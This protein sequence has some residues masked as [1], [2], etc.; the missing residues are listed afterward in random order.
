[1]GTRTTRITL[2]LAALVGAVPLAVASAAGPTGIGRM[3]VTPTTLT[4][5]S[6][7]NELTF[8]FTANRSLTGQTI[9]D[10]PRG[11][12]APQ[13][14]SASSP[15]Y[16]ELK[17]GTCGGST[18]IAPIAARRATDPTHCQRGPGLPL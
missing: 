6:T 14:R 7:G 5:G 8:T 2:L 17:R 9:V 1:M 13:R 12:S 18:R 4:A 15:G 16:V 10:V 11:W 3:I